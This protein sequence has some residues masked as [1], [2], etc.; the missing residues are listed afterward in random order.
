M[1]CAGRKACV[2]TGS[3]NITMK[4]SMKKSC[5]SALLAGLLMASACVL[6]AAHSNYALAAD[7]GGGGG[8]GGGG[9]GG[10]DSG[11][12]SGGGG[13]HDSG[14]GGKGGEEGGGHGSGGLKLRHGLSADHQGHESGV[15]GKE[16]GISEMNSPGTS[17]RF[18]GGSGIAGADQVPEGPGENASG[19]NGEL[20]THRNQFRNQFRY[21]GGWTLPGE[22]D[23]GGTDGIGS[24]DPGFNTG[25][26][27]GAGT[28]FHLVG[29]A[30]CGDMGT[31]N[32][33]NRLDGK[34]LV[35]F[36]EA[37]SLLAPNERLPASAILLIAN[38]QAELEKQKPD[39]VLAGTYIGNVARLPVTPE[40]IS[41]VSDGLCVIPPE[42]KKR[43]IANAAEEQRLSILGKSQQNAAH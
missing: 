5:K 24:T 20:S 4:N 27:G 10:H 43:E 41:Q 11:G 35:R 9:G 34:N 2:T 28:A 17:Q 12:G 38:Y 14:A 23:S 40:L 21:W 25:G 1:D 42:D 6:Y 36:R 15:H 7:E 33:G 29:E 26:G 39:P 8:S 37:R 22:G 3:G 16:K 32:A 13:G 18:G 31:L 30:R 19:G